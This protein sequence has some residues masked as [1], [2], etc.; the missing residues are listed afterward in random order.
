MSTVM[1]QD[2]CLRIPD[3]I[4]DWFSF[5][6][7]LHSDDFP[8]KTRVCYLAGEV[9]VEMSK[10]QV[11]SHNQVKNEYA[12]VLTGLAKASKSGRYFPDGLLL[13]NAETEFTAQPDGTYVS[14][15]A[16]DTSRVRL[17]EGT[18]DGYLELEGSP[19][20]VLE[21]VSNSS[22]EKDTV[23]LRDLYWQAGI[24]EHWLVDARGERLSFEIL[25]HTA[26][27]YTPVRRQNGWVKS[28]VFGKS[29]RLTRQ[30]DAQNNPEYALSVR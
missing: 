8:E 23:V 12:F 4:V 15:E 21:V 17:V 24:T 6:R 13:S 22:V 5:Q 18:K 25:R 7:W 26:K 11:F 20:M 16:F 14:H 1:L 19:D 2:V 10:E 30:F 3:R 28:S 27:G 9:W 29:F